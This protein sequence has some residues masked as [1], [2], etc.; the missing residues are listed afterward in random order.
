MDRRQMRGALGAL[1]AA[2]TLAGLLG[3]PAGAAAESSGVTGQAG[4][5]GSPYPCS[6]GDNT[7][8]QPATGLA[9][10]VSAI[11]W[12]GN[13]QGAVACLGGSF[14]VQ[15]GIDTTYG[16]GVYN[17]SPT[18]WT[19]AGGYLPALVTGFT[20][21]G[22]HVSI[23]NF[24]DRVLLDGHAY[25][26]I[27]SQ[28]AVHNPT[29]HPVRVNPEPSPGLLPLN[30]AP[31]TVP[32]GRTVDHDYVVA[33]DRF[34]NSYPWPTASQLE[35]AGSWAGHFAHM[36]AFWNARLSGITQLSLPDPQL[37]DAY[38]AGFI[39]TQIDRSGNQLDTG[40]NGYHA[41]YEHDVIGIL[42]NMFNEGD[43]SGAH[44]L[45]NEVDT[46]VG[47][48]GQYADGLWTYPW[49]W[50][51]YLEKTGDL[52]FLKQHFTKPGPLG[53]A[54]QPS[55]EA[56]AHQTAA[57]RTGP[58]GIMEETSDIDA[59]GYWTS[60]NFESLLGLAS[61]VYLAKAIG[62]QAQASWGE[63][64]YAS[65]QKAVDATLAHT[66]AT[67]HLDYLPCSMVE[68][69]SYNRCADPLDGNWAAPG[70]YTNEAWHGYLMGA[71]VSGLAGRSMAAWLDSTLSHG[72]AGTAG[73]VPPTTF[74][75]YPGE[76]FYSTTY[77]AGYG[78]WGI[79]ST[80]Y[81]DE[82]IL[83]NEFMLANDQS[84][85]YAWWEGSAA[86]AD[87]TPWIGN[88]PSSAGG[89][90][91]HSW[92]ISLAAQGLL[93]SLASQMAN[94]TLIAGRGVPNSWLAPGKS[95]NVSNFPVTDGHRLGLHI[96]S[97]GHAVSL[98]LNGTPSGPVVF[99]LPAFVNN[100]AGTSTGQVN[101]AAGT[102]T[103]A[104]GTPS[105]T[106]RL[107][108]LQLTPAATSLRADPASAIHVGAGGSTT[109]TATFGDS[110]PGA[111]RG[112]RL[113]VE[114][115]HGWRV[116]PLG[117]PAAASVAAGTT[118]T[119]RWR[120]TAPRGRSRTVTAALAVRAA[121]TDATTGQR[122]LAAVR[123]LGPPGISRLSVRRAAAGEIVTVE[124]SGFGRSQG[125]SSALQLT[126]QGITW[127][128]PGTIPTLRVLQW[129]DQRIVFQVPTPSGPGGDTYHVVP[130][131]TA[132]LQ[133]TTVGGESNAV[134]LPI[135]S[136]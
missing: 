21:R 85:P 1:A 115:P 77:N 57:D 106:V 22:A 70:V 94:G 43:F 54:K 38:R 13:D 64:E 122:E 101:E 16:Y 129:A 15:N 19:E 134:S 30:Q 27:Y 108:H 61:Y 84:G 23:T 103:I 97:T 120:L 32:P 92:G 90:S 5:A 119:G 37:A 7:G 72:F 69:N 40:T 67:Y 113:A 126:D 82:S 14:Y 116:T 36:R 50:A 65:L 73:V 11:G 18:T 68:P 96:A 93:D 75:G 10:D 6:T 58:G 41:E 4:P 80:R 132:A 45:L 86:P 8:F 46:V 118:V 55:I 78:A 128:A 102:V 2:V 28:V 35:H 17:Y 121:Y 130:G 25:V 42:A 131:T 52:A 3:A 125:T 112:L 20:D 63:N 95:I 34:G 114:A 49:L 51:I 44:A 59:N 104:P 31:N 109:V 9:V 47:T 74:G 133:V 117:S 88:H 135:V 110:G 56:T 123:E 98:S 71:K 91:P 29:A 105:V 124:G 33:S 136:G 99:D 12:L 60:D 53:A 127:S 100:I 48:N 66:V 89:A 26:A 87:T 76:G 39:Y 81:R 79:G 62:N 107:R 83:A 24:G 111:V